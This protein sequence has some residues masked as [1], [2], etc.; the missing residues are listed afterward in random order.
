MK[1]AIAFPALLL[2]LGI[3][4][5]VAQTFERDGFLAGALHFGCVLV[6]IEIAIRAKTNG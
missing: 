5:Q 6:I 3:S 2:G 1:F 4:G